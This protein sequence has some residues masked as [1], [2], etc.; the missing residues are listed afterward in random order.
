MSV[1]RQ[2]RNWFAVQELKKKERE[3]LAAVLGELGIDVNSA[4][5]GTEQEPSEAALKRKKK[6]E[7]QKKRE[8][9]RKAQGLP[10]KEDNAGG[11][12]KPVANGTQVEEPEVRATAERS[13]FVAVA[14]HESGCLV[15]LEY[16]AT[17]WCLVCGLQ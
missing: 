3:E 4:D 15:Q 7:E 6:R 16:F 17:T 11:D 9:E 13:R 8:E 12:G 1:F 5:G 10:A 14:V 2:R